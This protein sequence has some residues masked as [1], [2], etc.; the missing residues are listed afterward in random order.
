MVLSLTMLCSN[1]T[2]RFEGDWAETGNRLIQ[3][4][5]SDYLSADGPLPHA[6]LTECLSTI[7]TTAGTSPLQF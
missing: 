3:L 1:E 6:Y 2:R 7:E 5:A 4:M